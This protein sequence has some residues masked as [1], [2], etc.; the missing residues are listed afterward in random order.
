MIL[1]PSDSAFIPAGAVH[2]LYN[3]TERV[4]PFLAILS[5]AESDDPFQIDVQHE[6]PWCSLRLQVRE[7]VRS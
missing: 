1:R 4:L 6:E 2:G 5:P 3:D 7:G